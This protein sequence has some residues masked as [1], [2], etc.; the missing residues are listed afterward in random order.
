[1]IDTQPFPFDGDFKTKI[2]A[3]MVYDKAFVLKKRH[4]L[5]HKY[6]ENPAYV[7]ISKIILDF[8]DKYGVT[9]TEDS[10]KQEVNKQEDSR[11]LNVVLN[12]IK[13]ADL[14]DAQYIEDEVTD[15][16]TQ[17]AMRIALYLSEGYLKNKEYDKILPV[18]EKAL[19]SSEANMLDGL[20]LSDSFDI[21]KNYLSEE[22]RFENKIATF[23]R[24]VDQILRGGAGPGE[25]HM[26]FAPTKRGKSILLNGNAYA[27][28]MQGK[29]VTFISLEMSEKQILTRTHMRLSGMTDDELSNHTAKWRRS[30]KRMLSRG[31]DIYYKQF[32][33]KGLTLEGLDRFIDKLWKIER[34]STDL[35]IVDYVDIMKGPY[36]NDDGWKSQGPLTEGIRKILIERNIP[37]WTATQAGKNSGSKDQLDESDVRGDA[38]KSFATDSLWSI[39]QS[40][41]EE[42]CV[43]ARGRLKC[44]LLREGGGQGKVIPILFDKT[45]MLLTDWD[46]DGAIPF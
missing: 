39:L 3:L 43:P 36:D 26:I 46:E 11:L 32:P 17:Q 20:R 45:T 4:I 13:N 40:A 5:S 12:K 44:N 29:K 24:G 42:Q 15:F 33:T 27:G 38:T 23:I 2:L 34:Y 21:V 8:Y 7:T 31:G 22:S 6:F 19:L 41:E 14:S 37:G 1:M 30:F 18:I 10:L 9:P 16:C 35:L 28:A 25:L